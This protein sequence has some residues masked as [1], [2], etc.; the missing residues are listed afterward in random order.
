MI[1]G[2][3][4]YTYPGS[5]GVLINKFGITDAA[6]LDEALNDYASSAIA[7][8]D[9]KKLSLPNRP[10]FEMLQ[11]IHREMFQDIL[12][13]AAKLRDVEA[14]AIGTTSAIPYAS[15]TYLAEHLDSF[16]AEL[17]GTDYLRDCDAKAFPY[18]LGSRWGD[19]SALHPFRDG[20]TR[21]QS[22]YITLLTER[23]GHDIH[24][25]KIDVSTL[26]DLRLDAVKGRDRGLGAYLAQRMTPIQDQAPARA[27][28]L[29]LAERVQKRQAQAPVQARPGSQPDLQAPPHLP[30]PQQG[31]TGPSL[32]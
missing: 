17:E 24:W 19:P 21:S 2:D 3:D 25:E 12:P 28:L 27:G 10:T 23:A 18:E 16:Y 31:P 9:A 6:K 13:F 32:H 20:N 30:P 8:I 26:R 14:G 15:P 11:T 5:G 29:S 4:K 7:L 1:V 22:A